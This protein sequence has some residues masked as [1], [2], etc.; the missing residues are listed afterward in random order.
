MKLQD[1]WKE[2]QWTERSGCDDDGSKLL[3]NGRH[4]NGCVQTGQL[5]NGLL[6]TVDRSFIIRFDDNL[7]S[8][9]ICADQGTEIG[10]KPNRQ[11]VIRVIDLERVD[12]RV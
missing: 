9:G 8:F 1:L 3:E 5:Q 2:V 10:H 4:S 6:R 7:E 12:E 11:V